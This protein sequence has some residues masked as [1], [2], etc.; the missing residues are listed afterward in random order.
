MEFLSDSKIVTLMWKDFSIL[1]YHL[2]QLSLRKSSLTLVFWAK[3]KTKILKLA[4][5]YKDIS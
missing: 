4:I 3:Y 5:H 1:Y 2:K